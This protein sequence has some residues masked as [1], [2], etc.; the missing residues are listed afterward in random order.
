MSASSGVQTMGSPLMLKEVFKIKISPETVWKDMRNLVK[1]SNS[2][3][4][5]STQMN[6]PDD[7]VGSSVTI[8]LQEGIMYLDLKQ[9]TVRVGEIIINDASVK[10]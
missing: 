8:Y 9:G 10:E 1:N 3:F 2:D 6:K 5:H 7:L 4:A